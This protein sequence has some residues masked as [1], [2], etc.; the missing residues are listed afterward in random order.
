MSLL[1]QY[2][3]SCSTVSH[4]GVERSAGERK[5]CMNSSWLD[6]S[7]TGFEPG[8]WLSAGATRSCG[9]PFPLFR[10]IPSMAAS[11]AIFSHR[12]ALS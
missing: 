2:F 3:K 4:D 1:F 5:F 9:V 6:V 12:M 7:I 11:F 8:Y 10:G